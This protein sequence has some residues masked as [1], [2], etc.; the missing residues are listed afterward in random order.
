[1][2][3]RN[4]SEPVVDRHSAAGGV[5][6]RTMGRYVA[7][8][9]EEA[10]ALGCLERRP[11][12]VRRGAELVSPGR[13]DSKPFVIIEGCVVEYRLTSSGDR[14]ALDLLLM[15]EIANLR[16]T[17][18]KSTDIYMV[19]STDSVVSRFSAAEFHRL[20]A[21]YPRL[22]AVMVWRAAVGRSMLAEHLLDVGRRNALQRLGHR[23][24][25]LLVR[26]ELAGASDGQTLSAPLDLATLSDM[27]GLTIE[28]TS[29]MLRRLRDDGLVDT[30]GRQIRILDRQR[31]AELSEFDPSYLHLE[32]YAKEWD[33]RG[34][35]GGE[36]DPA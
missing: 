16:A 27:L 19:A 31:L 13:Q 14:Q 30:S 34:P 5:I 9:D 36:P 3:D 15:G 26:M 28:H 12:T 18:L 29:R 33:N 25:E 6:V 22:G 17:I 7:F 1:M 21:A 11:E 35:G 8:S 10:E 24:L 4:R 32:G 2:P 20:I 23:L